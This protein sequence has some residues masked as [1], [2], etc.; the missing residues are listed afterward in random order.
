MERRFASPLVIPVGSWPVIEGDLP[1][2]FM[3]KDKVSGEPITS[4]QV[5]VPVG[6]YARMPTFG[7][8]GS[9]DLVDLGYDWVTIDLFKYNPVTE[10]W[11]HKE[12]IF[13]NMD[14]VM[15]TDPPYWNVFGRD[16]TFTTPGNYL[17]VLY[18]Q[19]TEYDLLPR[20]RYQTEITVQPNWLNPDF[21]SEE[22]GKIFGIDVGALKMVAGV[23][24]VLGFAAVPPIIV[25]NTHP[26][27]IMLAACCGF[28]ASIALGLIPWW[29]ALLIGILAA[30]LLV[31]NVSGGGKTY[32]SN[33]YSGPR[34]GGGFAPPPPPSLPPD[35]GAPGGGGAPGV[36]GAPGAGRIEPRDLVI[37]DAVY[38]ERADP[39]LPS[40]VLRPT[41][42]VGYPRPRFNRHEP[43]LL[44]ARGYTRIR[45]R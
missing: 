42:N 33:E 5:N 8:D 29:V 27:V 19:T 20:L 28:V 22:G 34:D 24:L 30:A 6:L 32:I 40:N 12:K 43:R 9:Q 45:K 14:S 2:L 39:R 38:Y 36:G 21:L 25:G 4:T 41:F 7:G 15:F 37:H 18:Y 3:W 13:E 10:Q 35:G 31:M 16:V 26:M 23:L 1:G 17:A 44:I 11:E